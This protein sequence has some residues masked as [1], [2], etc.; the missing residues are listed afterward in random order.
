MFL[1]QQDGRLWRGEKYPYKQICSGLMLMAFKL[2]SKATSL[3]QF[4]E[5]KF[6]T[7]AMKFELKR[8]VCFWHKFAPGKYAIVPCRMG[9]LSEQRI[10]Q[11]FEL[12]VYAQE[13]SEKDSLILYPVIKGKKLEKIKKL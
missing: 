8:Q 2:D 3:E 13:P 1:I 6:V 10:Q 12:R 11:N 5:T 9:G 4:D 7:N